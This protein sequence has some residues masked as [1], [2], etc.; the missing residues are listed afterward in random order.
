[1]DALK[2]EFKKLVEAGDKNIDV[3]LRNWYP[4]K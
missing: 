1:M 4:G 3:R 2:A